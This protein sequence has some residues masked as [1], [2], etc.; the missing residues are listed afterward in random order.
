M[1]VEEKLQFLWD[2]VKD[3]A[4]EEERAA[5]KL[6]FDFFDG[7]EPDENHKKQIERLVDKWYARLKAV[8]N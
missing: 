2:Q 1:T 5:Y 3:S 7:P 4:T 6:C 8:T